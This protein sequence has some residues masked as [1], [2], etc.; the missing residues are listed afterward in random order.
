[1]DAI[2][3]G[4]FI[5]EMRNKKHL[6]QDEFAYKLGYD[7][8]KKISRWECGNSL[9]DFDD[10]I[11]ISE[12]LDVT[13]YELSICTKIKDKTIL[14]ATKDK[15]KTL[16]DYKR[17]TKR[18]QALII[19]AILL[20][21]LFG[22]TTL[23][24]IETYNTTKVYVFESMDEDFRIN[25]NLIVTNKFKI[26]NLIN[27]EYLNENKENL[28]VEAQKLEYYILYNKKRI[29]SYSFNNSIGNISKTL[30]NAINTVNF[31]EKIF[32]DNYFNSTILTFQIKY[33][34][35]LNEEQKIEFKFRLK[36]IYANSFKWL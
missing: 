16:K 14:D 23:F 8:S 6:T 28:N 4:K 18:K 33:N 31:S 24:T 3:L 20:G 30:I 21:T 17:F 34:N 9:P 5:A 36:E 10:L 1:M 29:L 19:I 22:L 27:I 32:K 15:L 25:G 13:L 2:K 12:V 35:N 26:F 7:N 11:R